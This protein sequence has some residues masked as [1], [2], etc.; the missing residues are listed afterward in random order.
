MEKKSEFL[1]IIGKGEL[2]VE[3]TK[4]KGPKMEKNYPRTYNEAK[5]KLLNDVNM[6]QSDI[7]RLPERYKL[8]QQVIC[9]RMAEGFVAKSFYPKAIGAINDIK[10][11]GARRYNLDEKKGSTD[12]IENHT[13]KMYFMRTNENGLKNLINELES[14]KNSFKESWCEEIQSIESIDLLMPQEKVL[15]FEPTWDGGRVE[16]VLHPFEKYQDEVIQK[17]F[18]LLGVSKEDPKVRYKAY[19]NGPVFVSTWLKKEDLSEISNYNPLRTVHPLQKIIIPSLRGT[20]QMDAPIAPKDSFKSSIKIGVFDG[21]ADTSIPLLKRYTNEYDLIKTPY[22]DD[23]IE[24]GSAVCGTILYG[25]LNGLDKNSILEIPAVCVE[26]FKVLPTS[27]PTDIDLYEIIDAIETV[28]PKRQDIKVYNLSLGPNGPI[29][30]DEVSRFTYALDKLTYEDNSSQKPLF[31]V[32]VGNDGELKPPY[33]RIQAPSDMVNGLGI[34]AYT[35]SENEI[36]HAPYSCVGLGREGCKVKPDIVDFGGCGNNPIHVISTIHNKKIPFAGTS[37]AS[38][39]STGVIGELLAAS[40]EIVPQMARTL[41]IH[42]AIHPYDKPDLKFGHG[43]AQHKIDE[44]IGCTQNKVTIIYSGQMKASQYVKL[45]VMLPEL[46]NF[47]GGISITWTITTLVNPNA[48]DTDGYTNNGIEDTFYPHS[49]RFKLKSDSQKPRTKTIN[50]ITQKETFSDF[51]ERGYEIPDFPISAS[52]NIYKSEQKRRKEFK[53]DT[54]VKRFR[55][56]KAVELYEPFLTL[57]AIGRNGYEH[58][59]IHYYT[60]ITI[61][62][63]EYDGNMYDSTIKK[64]DRLEPMRLRSK[65]EIMIPIN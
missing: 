31:C 25:A 5:L 26:S 60:V 58:E 15:N 40:D 36:V 48:L 8:E 37:F 29:L 21:G 18:R 9:V 52:G 59:G 12:T 28:V 30:D 24:H 63:P 7:N 4:K 13:S 1:P 57:H 43:Y 16:I 47:K 62:A 46:D 11:V 56:F 35:I 45:P 3:P 49:A 17:L 50:V 53:W 64:F 19:I 44:I 34:G 51:L 65:N 54:V 55:K 33:N 32:A 6:L 27:D 38:P 10:N 20:M 41:L 23:C 61:S 42:S 14:N 2:Y 39:N 22:M